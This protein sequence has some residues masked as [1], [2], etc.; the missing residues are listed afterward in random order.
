ML[1]L[2]WGTALHAQEEP[3]G[4]GAW[5]IYFADYGISERMS[6]HHE[7]HLHFHG[8]LQ[9][10]NRFIVRPGV[11]YRLTDGLV[12][13]LIYSYMY[14]DPTFEDDLPRG[15]RSD[16]LQE[17]RMMQQVVWRS[18]LGAFR[19]SHRVRVEQ[20]FFNDE[21]RRFTRHRFRYRALASLPL[22]GRWYTN[23]DAEA[24]LTA[25]NGATW[26]Y[27]LGA[28]LGVRLS[29]QMR[30][31]AGYVRFFNPG[32]QDERLKFIL[33]FTPDLRPKILQP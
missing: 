8:T 19:F 15:D 30:L 13:S 29:P 7:T 17:H 1:L 6:V 20:R 16:H 23:A 3:R 27:R 22:W 10:F 31:Q 5:Y 12:G 4:M 14:S 2:L 33:L 28:S 11:N 26:N 24:L 9:G 21:G 25:H 32:G 18:P